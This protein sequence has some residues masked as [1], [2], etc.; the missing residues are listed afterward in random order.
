MLKLFGSFET[1]KEVTVP[2]SF[3]R[4]AIVERSV[5]TSRECVE[6]A[7]R[8]I[9]N[10]STRISVAELDDVL[11][12]VVNEANNESQ[13]CG[14]TA[15][16]RAF[17]CSTSPFLSAMNQIFPQL[18]AEPINLSVVQ[19]TARK[20]WR[21]CRNDRSFQKLLTMHLGQKIPKGSPEPGT[22][23]YRRPA[24]HKDASVYR[25][26]AEVLATSNLADT[27]YLS[28][29]GILVR[30]AHEDLVH[31]NWKGDADE[32]RQIEKAEKVKDLVTGATIKSF[33]DAT[34]GEVTDATGDRAYSHSD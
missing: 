13:G 25:G 6:R 17:G 20:A 32:S 4:Y 22:L 24:E 30:A 12:T 11:A 2:Y 15:S 5:R 1:S 18:T 34:G 21:E 8:G 26:P 19:E 33:T 3:D 31:V 23:V 9:S 7:L 29:G 10:T 14:T 27:A 28:H 16:I